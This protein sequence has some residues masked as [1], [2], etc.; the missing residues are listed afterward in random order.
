MTDSF[1][2]RVVADGVWYIQDSRGGVMYLVAGQARA[3]LIDTGWGEGDL[4]SHIKTLTSLPVLVVNTHGHRDHTSGNG[5]F[6][7]VYIH[8]A[9]LP[10][11]EE[12]NARLIPIYDGYVFDLGQRDIRVIGVPGHSPGSICLLDKAARTLFSGDSPRPGPIFL[13]L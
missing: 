5:K 7:E 2:T 8:T 3:L 11:V 10:L 4:P 12:S 9:D 1:T 13:H 6:D